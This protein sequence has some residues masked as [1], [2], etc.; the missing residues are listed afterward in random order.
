M[1]SLELQ[2]LGSMVSLTFL[3]YAAID[4]EFRKQLCA[5]LSVKENTDYYFGSYSHFYI[6]EEMLKDTVRTLAY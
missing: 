4:D 5:D 6:H 3:S 1:A 2:T